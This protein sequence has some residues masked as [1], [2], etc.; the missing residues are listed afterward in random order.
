MTPRN[1][2][3]NY[4][5]MPLYLLDL[6]LLMANFIDKIPIIKTPQEYSYGCI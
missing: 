1:L 6:V 3:S 4:P 2:S 5:V